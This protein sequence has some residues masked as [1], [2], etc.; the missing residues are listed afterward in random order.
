MYKAG[1]IHPGNLL[2]HLFEQGKTLFESG[3]GDL[4]SVLTETASFDF[5]LFCY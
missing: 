1:E 5:C 4:E 2:F 3:Q